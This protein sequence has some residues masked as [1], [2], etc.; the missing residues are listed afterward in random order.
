[1]VILVVILDGHFR[2]VILPVT[3]DSHFRRSFL[4]IENCILT[5]IS[6]QSQWEY[7]QQLVVGIYFYR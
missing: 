7:Y 2:S 4:V 1:V 3:L 6:T 5:Q